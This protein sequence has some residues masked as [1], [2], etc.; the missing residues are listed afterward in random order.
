MNIDIYVFLLVCPFV[1]LSGFIDAIAGGGGFISLPAY[2]MSGIPAHLALGTNKLSAMMGTTITTYKYARLGYINFKR[3]FFAFI[4][5]FLGSALGAKVALLIPDKQFK[6]ALLF[7][8]PITLFIIIKNRNM[9]KDKEPKKEILVILLCAFVSFVFGIYD[10]IYGPGT[11]TFLIIGFCLIANCT[12]QSANGLTK[13]VNLTTNIA[14]FCVFFYHDSV[15]LPLGLTAGLFGIAG[16]YCGVK[17]FEKKGSFGTKPV[18]IF[19]LVLFMIKLS[20]DLYTKY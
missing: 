14:A 1:F 15:Y 12:L 4:T 8:L 18:M 13:A 3:A 10:G 11:G 17:F 5:G 16:N 2:F 20:Y 9:W 7:V 6:I 19:V